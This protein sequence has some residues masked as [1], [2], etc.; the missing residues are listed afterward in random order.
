MK[1]IIFLKKTIS[2]IFLIGLII[3]PTFVFAQTE[4]TNSAL[5]A[6]D[7]VGDKANPIKVADPILVILNIINYL[8]TFLGVVFILLI[9]YGGFVWM[10]AAGNEEKIKKGKEI[11]KTAVIGLIVI[12]LSR[13]FFGFVMDR[14]NGATTNPNIEP[15]GIQ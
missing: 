10:T 9:I 7:Q 15:G 5:N 11:L 12:V 8:L 13:V 1:R 4:G 2:I 6:L 14:I 3:I